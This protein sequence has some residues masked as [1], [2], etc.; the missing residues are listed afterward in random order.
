NRGDLDSTAEHRTLAS[1]QVMLQALAVAFPQ[2][3]RND[4]FREFLANGLLSSESKNAFRCRIEFYHPASRIHRD[5]AV[6]RAIENGAI[7]PRYP[8]LR[9]GFAD[10][11]V[12]LRIHRAAGLRIPSNRVSSP[13]LCFL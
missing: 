8:G 13:A 2:R 9:A 1:V 11:G 12:F 5:D 7:K 3:G 6:E 10:L 4:Q